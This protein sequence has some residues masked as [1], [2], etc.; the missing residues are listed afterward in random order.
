INSDPLTQTPVT[1]SGFCTPLA[2]AALSGRLLL[3][4]TEGDASIPGD[5]MQFGQ[6]ANTLVAISGPNNPI[7]NF[8]ASQI[9]NEAGTLD[10]TGS[11]GTRNQNAATLTNISG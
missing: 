5:Q 9:N 3:S 7:N 2:P 6:D 10:T 11:F 8:F 1:V 4:T